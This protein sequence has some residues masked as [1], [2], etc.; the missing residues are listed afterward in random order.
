M[1]R[2]VLATALVLL[3]MMSLFGCATERGYYDPG[4][5]TAAGALGGAAAGAAIGSIIGAATGSPATGAWVGGATGAIAGG[6]GGYL[7]SAHQNRLA[8]DRNTAARTY[9]YQPS[10]G[11]LVDIDAATVSPSTVRPGQQVNMQMTYTVLS[12]NNVPTTVTISRQIT[13]DGASVVQPYQTQVSNNNG[14]YTDQVGYT[15]PTDATPGTYTVTSRI[16][17]SY[18]SDTETSSFTVM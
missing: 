8:Y 12:P 7:Y 14:T 17:S 11:N 10:Q 2:K 4:R 1:T 16:T 6:L 13:K 9:S 5:S 18:G 15:V 3:F